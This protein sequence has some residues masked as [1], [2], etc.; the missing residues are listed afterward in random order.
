MFYK[1]GLIDKIRNFRNNNLVVGFARFYFCFTPNHDTSPTRFK[2]F[3]HTFV[4]IDIAAC[5]K[6]GSLDMLHQSTGI[7]FIVINISNN[8]VDTFRQV[9]WSNIGCHSHGNPRRTVYKQVGNTGRKNRRFLQCIVEIQLKIHR[10]LV[11]IAEHFLGQPVQ[12]RF[13]IPH[14]R[15]AVAIHAPHVSLSVHQRIAHT[16]VL[17][18][19]HHRVIYGRVAVGMVLTQYLTDNSGRFLMRLVGGITQ[20]R[21]TKKNTAVHR[22]KAVTHVGQRPRNN[23]RHRVIDVR[24][25]HF[26]F[27]INLDDSV[28]LINHIPT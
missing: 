16:P 25:L 7:N 26:I 12:P 3:F 13:G 23:N 10:F 5:R 21:H 14:G 22:L 4:T 17:C 28:F 1:V 2:S 9:V 15:G 11:D 20:F 19:P 24:R 18:E 8:P 6:I 27:D